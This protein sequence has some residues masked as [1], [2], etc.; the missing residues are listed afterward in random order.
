MYALDSDFFYL[1]FVLAATPPPVP[2]S[3]PITPLQL[4]DMKDLK[5][6]TWLSLSRDHEYVSILKCFNPS[7]GGAS[8]EDGP[9]TAL[10]LPKVSNFDPCLPCWKDPYR[11]GS[12]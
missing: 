7:S 9:E 10:T 6:S 11:T 5:S 8:V 1:T 12:I 2:Q 3:Y 4:P